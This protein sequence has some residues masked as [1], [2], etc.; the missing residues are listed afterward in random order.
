M[1]YAK[2]Y[3]MSV[4]QHRTLKLIC[5]VMQNSGFSDNPVLLPKTTNIVILMKD[6]TFMLVLI[7]HI[8][9]VIKV[10]SLYEKYC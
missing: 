7:V 10:Y 5:F 9:I 1:L 6:L 3:Q 4:S 8:A 2:E